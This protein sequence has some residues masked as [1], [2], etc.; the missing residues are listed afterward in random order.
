[1]S[2]P[3]TIDQFMGVFALYNTSIWPAQVLLNLLAVLAVILCFKPGSPSVLVPSV[4]GLLWIWT[5]SVYHLMFFSAINP[6]ARVAGW[7]F[8]VQG[9]LFLYTGVV[10]HDLRFRFTRSYRGIAG[11]VII[12]YALVLY[13]LL[14]YLFGH[15]YPSSPTFGAPCPTTIFTF[16][17]LLWSETRP[18]WFT[19]VIPVAWAFFG[20]SA[21]LMFGV[22][23]D[24]GLFVSALTL[25]AITAMRGLWLQQKMNSEF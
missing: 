9:I 8:I 23:E 10:K 20:S 24:A 14:G 21:A 11:A 5:G 12:L 18:R 7:L 2:L 13:P 16:G 25:I 3:F 1:M 4:L 17:V 6:V 22:V 15:T 19:L